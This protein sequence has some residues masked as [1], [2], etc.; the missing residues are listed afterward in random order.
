MLLNGDYEKLPIFFG[1]NQHEGSFIY[2]LA[3]NT[4]LKPN[5]FT[6]DETFLKYDLAEVMLKMVGIDQGY[7][8]SDEIVA[9]YFEETEMGDLKSM[10]PGIVDVSAVYN[11]FNFTCN[12]NS[13]HF[14]LIFLSVNIF[15]S[16]SGY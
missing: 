4:F 15:V 3:Y 10:T 8:F 14:Y 16:K 6:E 12:E 11:D 5:N 13:M 9:K 1:A 2:G 7:A